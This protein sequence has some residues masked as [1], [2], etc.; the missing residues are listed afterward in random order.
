[1]FLV[2]FPQIPNDV[3]IMFLKFPMQFPK[4]SQKSHTFPSIFWLRKL[5]F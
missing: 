5:N 1:M 2:V 4:C 3:P